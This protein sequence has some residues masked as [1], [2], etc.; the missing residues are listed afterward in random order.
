MSKKLSIIIPTLGNRLLLDKVVNSIKL[1][2]P[3]F[4]E[5]LII[6]Q[7]EALN[8]VF[9]MKIS[10]HN[11]EFKGLSK[12]KNYGVSLASGDYILFLDDDAELVKQSVIN[13]N[14]SLSSNYDVIF[15]KTVDRKLIDTVKKF[16]SIST[17]LSLKNYKDKFIESTMIVKSSLINKIKF[18]E[19]FGAG[20]FYGAEEGRDWVIRILKLGSYKLYYDHEFLVYHPSVLIDKHSTKSI[21]RVI[22]YRLGY[23]ALCKKHK[24]FTELIYRLIIVILA[25]ILYFPF[26]RKTSKY[27]SIEFSSIIL[28]FKTWSKT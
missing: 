11:V 17:D 25:T 26:K 18:D 24:L 23:G 28:G 15:G 8:Q 20:C 10:V 3:S 14:K 22:S 16:S 27:Y 9:S 2:Y 19:S 4:F 12:A 6:N 7:G 5:V 1:Y 13:I 21:K